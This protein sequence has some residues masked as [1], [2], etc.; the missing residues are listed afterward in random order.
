MNV[1]EQ[2]KHIGIVH[3]VDTHHWPVCVCV[4][5]VN[6]LR[7]LKFRKESVHMNNSISQ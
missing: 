4:Y 2:S 7:K 5:G 3:K 6:D 1:I